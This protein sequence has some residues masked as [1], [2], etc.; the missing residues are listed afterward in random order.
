MWDNLGMTEEQPRYDQNPPDAGTGEV[1]QQAVI[2]APMEEEVEVPGGNSVR[3]RKPVKARVIATDEGVEVI[4]GGEGKPIS[5]KD[6]KKIVP[7]E[8]FKKAESALNAEKRR[9]RRQKKP[10]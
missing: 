5:K 1:R 6:L 4:S 8:V 10:R 9:I 2:E 3:R 7:K